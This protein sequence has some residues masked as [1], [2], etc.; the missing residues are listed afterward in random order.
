MWDRVKKLLATKKDSLDGDALLE[1][2]HSLVTPEH[3]SVKLRQID[4]AVEDGDPVDALAL[5]RGL[6]SE[7]PARTDVLQRAVVVL[8][9]VGE[10]RLAGLFEETLVQVDAEAMS[11]LSETFCDL[12][13]TGIAMAFAGAARRLGGSDDALA[14]RALGRVLA[15]EGHHQDVV[16]VLERFEGRWASEEMLQCYA[17]ASILTGD[18]SR[19]NRIAGAVSQ[20]QEG[21][22][23]IRAAAR[24][25]AFGHDAT[26]DALRHVHFIQYGST[27]IHGRA[28]LEDLSLK[29]AHVGQ[30]LS[31]VGTALKAAGMSLDRVSSVTPKGEVLARWLGTI[32]DV[33]SI[34]LSSRLPEQRVALLVADDDDLL[35]AIRRN[36]SIESPV[37]LIQLIRDPGCQVTPVA[38]IVGAFGVG[39]QLPLDTVLGTASERIPPSILVKQLIEESEK[40][41]SATPS[42]DFHDW[43]KKH[44]RWLSLTDPPAL[45]ARLV[46]R[47][48]IP[49][50]A[51]DPAQEAVETVSVETDSTEEDEP[52][53]LESA[54]GT[55]EVVLE[56]ESA[57][58]EGA[59]DR[60]E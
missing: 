13:D 2:E 33:P 11:Q 16:E 43:V 39:V 58:D 27:L 29:A 59:T 9:R 26:V 25:G 14:A 4:D 23:L 55:E 30:L 42:S 22:G 35:E 49:R 40:T 10:A 1:Q 7:Y 15:R 37:V 46:Y 28:V 54:A 32:I 53:D 47:A 48:N 8:D 5:L 56:L 24:V 36:T 3:L 6:L 20:T 12:N 38:D 34:P 17:A 52:A 60:S 57:L 50:W 44:A 19:W 18:S 51:L 45:S 31:Q 21:R 41:G